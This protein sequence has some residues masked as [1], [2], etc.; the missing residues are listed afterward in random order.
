MSLL[1]KRVV[2]G[3]TTAAVIAAACVPPLHLA[4][5]G[6]VGLL[7]AGSLWLIAT[8]V[9]GISYEGKDSTLLWR[10]RRSV[11]RWRDVKQVDVARRVAGLKGE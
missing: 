5:L 11:S 3:T 1:R 9:Y 8:A 4:R 7:L 6:T 2:V 10:R